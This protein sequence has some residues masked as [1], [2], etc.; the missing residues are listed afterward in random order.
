MWRQTGTNPEDPMSMEKTFSESADQAGSRRYLSRTDREQQI[1]DSAITL[2]AKKGFALTTREL[3]QGL[4]ITQ[5]LLYRYFPSKQMLIERVYTQ[6]FMSRFDPQWEVG[7]ADRSRPLRERLVT[8][9][10]GYTAVILNSTWVR[11]FL[12]AGLQDPSL[13]QRYLEVLHQGVLQT[14]LRELRWARGQR[15][16]AKAHQEL[17][18]T[19]VL[20]GF[21]SSFFY[22][23]VRKWVYQLPIPTDLH[24]VIE[25]RVDAFLNG[26]LAV[27]EP[28]VNSNS[29]RS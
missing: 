15:G 28:D 14:I 23:G 19:E 8:Y 6:V 2:F 7:L 18:D 9:F 1:V 27:Q 4:G 24:A 26:V 5:P 11:I 16:R 13:N 22:L 3:A 29:T 25:A 20:W 17:L 10:D 12:F 21:H